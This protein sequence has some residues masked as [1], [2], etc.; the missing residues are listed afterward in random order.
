M[1]HRVKNLFTLAIS[2]LTL[3]ARYA[4]SVTQL[5]ENTRD[6]LSALARAHGLTL[7]HGPCAPHA[8]RPA[9]L[10]SLLEAITAPHLGEGDNRRVSIVGCDME[11]FGVDDLK[12]RAAA[13]RVRDKF[14]KVWGAFLDCRANRSPLRGPSWK[15]RHHLV[16]ARR[17]SGHSTDWQRRIRR[18]SSS[19]HCDRPAWGRHLSGMEAGR[20]G[21]QAFRAQAEPDRLNRRIGRPQ[22]GSCHS[23]SVLENCTQ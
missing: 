7:S 21:H 22:S 1:D 13:A 17:S 9:T 10:H 19:R 2:V 14:R 11:D 12:P 8:A 16:R 3:S 20:P 5:I 15:R 4:T 6:R 18:S 23:V